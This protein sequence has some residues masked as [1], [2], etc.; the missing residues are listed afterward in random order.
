MDPNEKP[1]EKDSLDKKAA[2]IKKKYEKRAFVPK[3]KPPPHELL[4]QGRDPFAYCAGRANDAGESRSD[5]NQVAAPAPAAPAPAAARMA[6]RA[7]AP[8]PAQTPAPA[9]SVDLLGG[10]DEPAHSPALS[11]PPPPVNA[12]SFIDSTAVPLE[13]PP[14]VNAFSFIESTAAPAEAP[15]F[16][17]AESA[18]APP[19]AM[20]DFFAHSAAKAQQQQQLQQS[21]QQQQPQPMIY[22]AQNQQIGSL[23]NSLASL[24][25][26]PAPAQTNDK[27]RFDALNGMVLQNHVGMGIQLNGTLGMQAMQSMQPMQPMQPIQPMQP[28]PLVQPRAQPPVQDLVPQKPAAQKSPV[29][30]ASAGLSGSLND[31]MSS[32][33]GSLDLGGAGQSPSTGS[34]TIA[35][36]QRNSGSTMEDIDAFAGFGRAAVVP[37]G[38]PSGGIEPPAQQQKTGLGSSMQQI[39][40]MGMQTPAMGTAGMAAIGA[41]SAMGAIGSMNGMIGMNG[42]GGMGGMG[43]PH[44]GMQPVGA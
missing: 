43:M 33:I 16:S 40:G 34:A 6:V 15:S 5:A 32:I 4:A 37:M 22:T 24:Y 30:S 7:P 3:G 1:H 17:S 25:Q 19:D 39:G 36:T 41:M 26:Q 18:V 42:M 23:Q 29:V 44:V 28:M 38:M 2:F 8:K 11:S 9:P 21:Q 14:P 10:M 13:A 35:D 20:P 31:A 27:A 12:F